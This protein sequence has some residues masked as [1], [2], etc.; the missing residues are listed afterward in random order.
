MPQE[1]NPTL[2]YFPAAELVFALIY[3]IGTEHTGLEGAIKDYLSQFGYQTNIIRL[4]NYF[5]VLLERLG[6]AWKPPK[7]SAPLAHYKIDAG[8]RIR[9]LTKSNNI[10][11]Y[12]AAGLIHGWRVKIGAAQ[13]QDARDEYEEGMQPRTAHVILSLKR[14][15]E[16]DTL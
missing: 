9:R 10:L 16:A 4:S 13:D 12:E 3:P 8:N 11:A 6:K 5:P 7:G 1:N 2:G 14:P 15:E